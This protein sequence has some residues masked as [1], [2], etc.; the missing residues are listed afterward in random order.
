MNDECINCEVKLT[1]ENCTQGAMFCDVCES[2]I[3]RPQGTGTTEYAKL[4]RP[5]NNF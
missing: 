5:T 1:D 4:A 3:E 2:E